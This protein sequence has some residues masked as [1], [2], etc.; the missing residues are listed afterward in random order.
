MVAKKVP[1]K[2]DCCTDECCCTPDP[3]S[4]RPPMS[5]MCYALGGILSL[6]AGI[7]FLLAAYGMLDTQPLYIAVGILLAFHGLGGVFHVIRACPMCK[8]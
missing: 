6:F 5:G 1:K 7:V 4:T 2:E 3:H 8:K